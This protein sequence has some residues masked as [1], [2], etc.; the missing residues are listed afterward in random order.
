MI[1]PP[2]AIRLAGVFC[3]IIPWVLPQDLLLDCLYSQSLFEAAS[4]SARNASP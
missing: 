2:N 3:G 1:M 4:Y